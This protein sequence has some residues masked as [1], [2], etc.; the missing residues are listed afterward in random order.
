MHQRGVILSVGPAAAFL[1]CVFLVCALLVSISLA[2]AAPKA[3]PRASEGSCRQ[4]VNGLISLLDAKTDSNADSKTDNTLLYR[5]T[6]AVV[7]NT[8]GPPAPNAKP[9]PGAS[10][11][12]GVACH[13]LAAALVDL[14][15]DGK[16][17]TATFVK[18][19]GDFAVVCAPR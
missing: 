17:N 8:C 1:V 12:G 18:A 4:A 9:E 13:D 6:Y 11:P 15:E 19:R 10:P 5:D 16:M 7:V 3:A 14:I 2:Y